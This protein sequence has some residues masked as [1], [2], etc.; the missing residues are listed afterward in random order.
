MENYQ[1]WSPV[2]ECGVRSSVPCTGDAAGICVPCEKGVY[3][4]SLRRTEGC[5]CVCVCLKGRG[6][7]VV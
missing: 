3:K 6:F 7:E 4:V 2:R 5:V 1:D